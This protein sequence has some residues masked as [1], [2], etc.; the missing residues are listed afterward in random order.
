M[1]CPALIRAPITA[2]ALLL[3]AAA[4]ASAQPAPLSLTAVRAT[5]PP[6]IDGR[7]DDAAWTT[8]AKVTSLVQLRPTE[9]APASEATDV[10]LAYDSQTL[11]VGIHARYRDT[12]LVRATRADRDATANDD[13][14]TVMFDPFL[15]QQRGY[16]FSVNAYGVQS[17][18]LLSG[19]A[20]ATPDTTWNVLYRSAGILVEDGWTAEMAIPIKSLRYPS[21][22]AGQPHTWGFQ[23]QREIKGNNETSTWRPISNNIPGPLAQMGLLTGMRDF[24]TA[25]NFELLPT[26]TTVATERLASGAIHK[27]DIAEAGLNMK[28]GLSSNVTLDV[29]VNPDFSQIES[30]RPQIEINQRFPLFFPELRPFFLEGQEIFRINGPFN[31]LHTRTII[32]PQ[33]GAKITGK[34]GRTAFGLL[35]ANDQAAGRLD[36]PLTPGFGSAAGVVSGRVRVDV[37]RESFIGVLANDREFGTSHSRTAIFDGS[38]RF[39]SNYRLQTTGGLTRHVDAAGVRRTG[40]MSDIGFSKQGRSLGFVVAQNS[41]SPDFRND[42]GFQARMNYRRLF[43]NISYRWWPQS[44]VINWGPRIG[45]N[46]LYDFAGVLNDQ[47]TTF[48]MQGAFARNVTLS[49]SGGR[50][51]ERFQGIDFWK[52]RYTASATINTSRSVLVRADLS[53]GD[54]VRFIAAPYLGH[55]LVYSATVTL[56]PSSRFQSEI[57]LNTTRFTDVRTDVVDFDVKVVRAVTTYQFTPR[58]LIRNITDLNT[59][60][61]TFGLNVMGTYRVN[62]GTVFFVGYDDRYRQGQR[63]DALHYTDDAYR[64]TN[65]ALFA[66]VQYLFRR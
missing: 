24:S 11:Y 52:M 23:V 17:D 58:L 44:W 55:S 37:G 39:G 38:Y 7:L 28:Y 60:N 3:L 16:A 19:G 64:R 57:T 59:L 65:R 33:I 14:V 4:R 56:R 27:D 15:D 66:K 36:N 43:S 25:R 46:R 30:D 32:D 5:L 62:A 10:F 49:G 41:V 42:A 48:T 12:G 31:F 22:P 54:E 40:H 51:L 6:T 8:A 26:A 2:T 20:F 18:A 45:H 1:R 53:V 47:D 9:G 63:I 35:V 29:T 34:S 13:T 61:K 50:I 21:R